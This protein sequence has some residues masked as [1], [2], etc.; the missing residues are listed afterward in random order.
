MS[1]TAHRRRALSWGE[2]RS[3]AKSKVLAALARGPKTVGVLL[4]GALQNCTTL[5][6]D[7]D[8]LVKELVDDGLVVV[9]LESTGRPGPKKT[10]CTLTDLGRVVVSGVA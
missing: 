2:R 5:P 10:V 9:T 7:R 6:A 8:Q 3:I 4:T 1:R